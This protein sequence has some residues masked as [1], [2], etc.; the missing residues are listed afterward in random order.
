MT[1]VIPPGDSEACFQ[2]LAVDD[3][4]VEDDELFTVVVETGNSNDILNETATIIMS[5]NDG[6]QG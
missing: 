6:N 3:E 4:T 2:L 1:N 5:D